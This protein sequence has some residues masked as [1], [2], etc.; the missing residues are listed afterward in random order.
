MI[1]KEEMEMV[2]IEIFANQSVQQVIT[3]NLEQIIPGFLYSIVPLIHGRGKKSYKLGTTTWPETNFML[4]AYGDDSI[5][6]TVQRVIHY[7]K[8]KFPDEGIK[9]FIMHDIVD[10]IE[11]YR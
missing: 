4:I 2:R 1:R 10:I 5:E 7:I 6:K 11:K 8:T 3:D 9:L